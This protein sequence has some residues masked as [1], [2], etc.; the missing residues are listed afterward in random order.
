MPYSDKQ[1]LLAPFMTPMSHTA[2]AAIPH[3]QRQRQIKQREQ[4]WGVRAPYLQAQTEK[5][6]QD[7]EGTRQAREE[8]AQLMGG[9]MGGMQNVL[10]EGITPEMFFKGKRLGMFSP[11]S[12]QKSEP[13]LGEVYDPTNKIYTREVMQPGQTTK[14]GPA[15][16]KPVLGEV[17]HQK[18]DFYTREPKEAGQLTRLGPR[19]APPN[20]IQIMNERQQIMQRASGI[21]LSRA[22]LEKTG[23]L[24]QIGAMLA[25]QSGI[26]LPAGQQ[27]PEEYKQI[28]FKQWD[29][30][31][32]Q[33]DSDL[34]SL[35]GYQIPPE[36]LAPE[37]EPSG[38]LDYFNR[39]INKK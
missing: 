28:L 33:L 23:A 18:G 7:I 30:E 25:Q 39:K 21:A 8:Y 14:P 10:P 2:L 19:S 16:P 4:E 20:Q 11:L 34:K 15:E 13:K 26:A 6:Q 32:V 36:A 35:P 27:I 1:K 38:A 29:L 17:Y 24:D 22:T 5:T 37:Q 9:N 31:L 12:M 3:I